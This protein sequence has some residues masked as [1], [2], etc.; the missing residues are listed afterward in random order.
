MLQNEVILPIEVLLDSHWELQLSNPEK[1]SKICYQKVYWN[2]GYGPVLKQWVAVQLKAEWFDH[3]A[4][5]FYVAERR[6]TFRVFT[7]QFRRWISATLC[8]K[9][10]LIHIA[11]TS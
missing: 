4:S 7:I 1:R 3:S 8:S 11:V 5:G 9:N 6:F 10:M 2:S